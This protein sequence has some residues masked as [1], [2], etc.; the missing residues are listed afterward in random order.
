MSST[1]PTFGTVLVAAGTGTRAGNAKCSKVYRELAGE[2]V[3]SRVVR[4]FRAW[5]PGHPIVIVRHEND[6][7]LLTNAIEGAD[8]QVYETVCEATR[9]A[10]V[11]E[12]LRFLSSLEQPPSH[13]LFH[14]AARPFIPP[15][16][17]DKI[18]DGMREQPDVGIILAIPVS[19]TIKSV[20]ENGLYR[21][22][23]PQAFLLPTALKIHDQLAY[24]TSI[25]Y[26]DDQAYPSV[27]Y[28]GEEKNMKLTYPT[29]FEQAERILQ[30][31]P[32]L[33]EV[34][35][36]D[37]RVGHGYD[38]HRL[39]PA[40]EIILCGVKIPHTSGL[41]GH[42]DADVGLHA[43]TNALLG[44]I[45]ADDIG[46]R[47]SPSDPRWKGA[48]SDQF[49]RHARK[50]V[51]DAGG[52]ITH[53]DV[54]LICER[55]K[56]GPHR[57]ALKTSVARILSLDKSRVSIKAGTNEKVGFVG[58]E[59]GIIGFATV[60]AVFPGGVP[61]AEINPDYDTTY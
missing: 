29:D 39:I 15:S 43:V 56:I 38:T 42:S 11:L 61:Q 22:Q 9:Q 44:R 48:S 34:S 3:I 21:A 51:S 27:S 18:R 24:D 31:K 36:P 14:D 35:I 37:V 26:T 4:A 32:R 59:E 1:H 55:P 53:V 20:A 40:T 33:P 50:L 25:E 30:A 54:S 57:D 52:V 58:R 28:K 5:D 47:F 49:V 10:S 17:L 8:G 41:L 23:T 46:S 13:V 45:G 6:A 2:T 19:D 12:G 7:A 60:T 16:L